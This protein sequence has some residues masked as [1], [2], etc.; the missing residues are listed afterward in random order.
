MLEQL[1]KIISIE[2]TTK[3]NGL[4]ARMI[5]LQE[6][7]D[8]HVQEITVE[9]S[10]IKSNLSVD[11]E[12]FL[13]YHLGYQIAEKLVEDVAIVISDDNKVKV[14]V[15]VLGKQFPRNVE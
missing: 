11:E 7:I 5:A 10:V 3:K 15:L 4:D 13:K 8:T 12:D 14:S 1:K 9:N 6:W 2:G